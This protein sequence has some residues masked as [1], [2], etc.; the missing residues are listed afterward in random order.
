LVVV[1]AKEDF[2]A[3]GSADAVVALHSEVDDDLR[4]EG[5]AREVVNRVQNL[6]KRIGL[7]YTDRIRLGVS[8]DTAVTEAVTRFE[9]TIREETLTVEVGSPE[10]EVVDDTIDGHAI[11]ISI[12]RTVRV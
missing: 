1:K 9:D 12:E 7:G 8:G 4:Q 3:M 5:L 11:R 10:G 2:E 6:R